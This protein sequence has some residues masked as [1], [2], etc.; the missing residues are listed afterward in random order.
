MSSVTTAEEEGPTHRGSSDGSPNGLGRGGKAGTVSRGL[1]TP[2]R[3]HPASSMTRGPATET[4]A[5]CK[6]L[7]LQL[8]QNGPEL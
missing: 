7:R 8:K 4:Q 6:Y 2:G 3:E 5:L 1:L